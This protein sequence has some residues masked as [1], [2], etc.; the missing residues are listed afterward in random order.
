MPLLTASSMQFRKKSL[1]LVFL[2]RKIPWPQGCT[3]DVTL[4][5]KVNAKNI[6]FHKKFRRGMCGAVV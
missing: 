1:C 4:G 5:E 3:K 6:I 2:E